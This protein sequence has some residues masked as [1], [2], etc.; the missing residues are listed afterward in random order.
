MNTFAI[1]ALLGYVSAGRIPLQKR[2]LT[3]EMLQSQQEHLE[4]K[5]LGGEHVDIKDYMN[6]QY[7]IQASVG[8]PPQDFTVVPDTGSSNLWIYSHSCWSVV[9]WT[10]KTYD[11]SKSSTYVKDG[12]AFDISYGSGSV[13]G[14]TSRDIARI[15]DIESHMSLGEIKSAKGTAFQVSQMSGILGLAYNS[16]SVDGLPTFMDQTNLKDKSFSFYL[17]NNPDESYMVIPGMDTEG[18]TAIQSHPVVEKKYWA[19][20]MSSIKKGDKVIDASNYKAVI[21]SGTSLIAGPKALVADLIEGITIESD[22]SNLATQPTL[23]ITIDNQEYPLTA[24]DYVMKLSALGQ[25]QCIL[26]IQAMDVPTGFN[27]LILGDVFMR[28]Y[29]SYFNLDNNTVTFQVAK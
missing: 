15:G 25:T 22:C 16:I 5:F 12:T 23:T 17:H 11:S 14:F 8:T 26:G 7:F 18:Y 3:P 9:C 21:D 19:L 10:H 29:P 24:D 13:S 4:S 1:A 27:Y 20:A 6:A 2:E 28:K